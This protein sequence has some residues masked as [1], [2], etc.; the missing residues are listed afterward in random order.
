MN[1]GQLALEKKRLNWVLPWAASQNSLSL[2]CFLIHR[3]WK[4][5][6]F[7]TQVLLQIHSYKN[8]GSELR[9]VGIGAGSGLFILL[10]GIVIMSDGSSASPSGSRFSS[11]RWLSIMTKV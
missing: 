7:N 11:S 3:G 10:S 8:L 9:H 6:T 1:W 4:S 5:G 2:M